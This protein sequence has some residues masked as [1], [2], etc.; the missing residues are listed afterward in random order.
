MPEIIRA[1]IA[2]SIAIATN[3]ST[4][5]IASSELSLKILMNNFPN[6]IAAPEDIFNTL[7]LCRAQLSLK[8]KL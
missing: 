3:P 8:Y 2:E 6:A 7:N 1:K 5:G 4:N